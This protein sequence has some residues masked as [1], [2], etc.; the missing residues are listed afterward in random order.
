MVSEPSMASLSSNT[1]T[2]APN[3]PLQASSIQA[4]LLL[5]SNMA[6]LMSVKLD[7]T[8][9]IVWKHQL[10]SI[11][12]AY[13]MIEFVDGTVQ[14]PSRFLVDTEGNCTTAV[15]PD[16]QLYNTRDKLF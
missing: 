11:L 6:N 5:L 2:T 16:F 4:P 15:N 1:N 13:S 9:F 7:S 10:S 14:S 12:K 3:P 8:N